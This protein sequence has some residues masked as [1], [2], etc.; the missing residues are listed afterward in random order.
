MNGS[1][2]VKILLIIFLNIAFS[3]FVA[4]KYIE[5]KNETSDSLQSF[6][7]NKSLVNN[8]KIVDVEDN[9]SIVVDLNRYD[10]TKTIIHSSRRAY[11]T[12]EGRNTVVRSKLPEKQCI[13]YLEIQ[14][15]DRN[16]YVLEEQID[17]SDM[18][19]DIPVF[20]S[21]IAG[22]RK[23]VIN[24]LV[25]KAFTHTHSQ[26]YSPALDPVMYKQV[27]F[28]TYYEF[29]TDEK[30][31]A[32]VYSKRKQDY[33]YEYSESKCAEEEKEVLDIIETFTLEL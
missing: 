6:V 23:V 7:V 17:A 19:N 24:G 12:S 5:H 10:V 8:K 1:S 15:R 16:D 28:E 29:L 4:N 25:G 32:L 20:T 22:T 11:Q 9:W 3:I 33:D 31:Y 27:F 13:M 30:F 2:V 14:V 21:D 26:G 18:E